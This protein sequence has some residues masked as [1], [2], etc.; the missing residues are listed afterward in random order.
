MSTTRA[1][2]ESPTTTELAN[3]SAA[4]GFN[5]GIEPQFARQYE[6]G[7]RARPAPGQRLTAA[8]YRIDLDDELIPFELAAF[9][10]RD[11][12]ANAGESERTGLELAWQGEFGDGWRANAAYTWSDF[13]FT[14]FTDDDGDV[15]DGNTVPGTAEHVVFAGLEYR[16]PTGWFTAAEA[17]HTSAIV[18]DNANTEA[19]D[20]FTLVTL[21]AGTE[22]QLALRAV[23]ERDQPARRRLHGQRAHQCVRGAVLRAR[24]RA[25]RVR[26]RERHSG[27]WRALSPAGGWMGNAP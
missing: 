1:S 14:D 5:P 16:A 15:F 22:W 27:T 11:F 26:G 25:Q 18:L 8:L 21:R 12:F 24:A 20:A 17:T 6:L 13:E 23:C 3:P 9:P 2:F 19:A 4:G 7:A 10:G